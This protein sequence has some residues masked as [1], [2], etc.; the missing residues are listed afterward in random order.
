MTKRFDLIVG[1]VRAAQL[2]NAYRD[3]LRMEDLIPDRFALAIACDVYADCCIYVIAAP[4]Q[5]WRPAGQVIPKDC[6][7]LDELYIDS[8]H[9]HA[10]RYTSSAGIKGYILL[11]EL[12]REYELWYWLSPAVVQQEEP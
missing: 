5:V 4:G 3:R 10:A 2:I 12:D 11:D 8:L 9:G 1:S 6:L 7:H